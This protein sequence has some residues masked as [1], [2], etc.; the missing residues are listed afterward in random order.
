MNSVDFSYPKIR[1]MWKGYFL[2]IPIDQEEINM[3]QSVFMK[4]DEVQELLGVSRSEAYRIMKNG[5]SWPESTS[6][7]RRAL[8]AK[9]VSPYRYNWMLN[10]RLCFFEKDLTMEDYCCKLRLQE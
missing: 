8:L 1:N 4:A 5:G 10:Q 9:Y 2:S 7:Y 6:G 3:V